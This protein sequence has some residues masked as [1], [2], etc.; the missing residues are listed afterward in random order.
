MATKIDCFFLNDNQESVTVP[1]SQTV[2]DN[3]YS[4]LNLNQN[5]KCLNVSPIQSNSK[6][7]N[8]KNC[9]TAATLKLPESSVSDNIEGRKNPLGLNKPSKIPDFSN[10]I[11]DKTENEEFKK[12]WKTNSFSNTINGS[13][14]SLRIAAY[15]NLAKTDSF[16][17]SKNEDL[18]KVKS[19]SIKNEKQI[20]TAGTFV[21]QNPFEFPRQ[22]NGGAKVPEVSSFKASQRLLNPN[23]AS[24]Y[25]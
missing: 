10:L 2:L 18:Q 12:L 24:K 25:S 20:F 1:N 17:G 22:E 3:Q 6:S 19:D 14:H 7:Y 15:E 9:G 16:N 4:N 5:F 13:T 8:N 21:I 11:N 23:K